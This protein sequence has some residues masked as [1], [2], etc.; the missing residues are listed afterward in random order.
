MAA[1]ASGCSP[2]E[3]SYWTG[4]Y[5]QMPD[6]PAAARMQTGV[7]T[8]SDGDLFIN[9]VIWNEQTNQ[10]ERHDI[11]YTAGKFGNTLQVGNFREAGGYKQRI[12]QGEILTGGAAVDQKAG[13]L[14]F[15]DGSWV[16]GPTGAYLSAKGDTITKL[17]R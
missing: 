6:P 15:P 7:S 12:M 13:V 3:M 17:E 11:H 5:T 1:A 10:F 14:R 2:K 16:D 9:Y 8:E 4:S